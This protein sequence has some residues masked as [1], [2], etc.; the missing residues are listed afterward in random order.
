MRP[1]DGCTSSLLLQVLRLPELILENRTEVPREFDA[2]N[3]C[4]LKW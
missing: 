1:N 4:M 2:P 3:N